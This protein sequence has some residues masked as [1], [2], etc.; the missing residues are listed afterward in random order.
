MTVD[1]F[2]LASLTGLVASPYSSPANVSTTFQGTQ[3]AEFNRTNFYLVHCNIVPDGLLYNNEYSSILSDVPI[4]VQPLRQILYNPQNPCQLSCNI[5]GSIITS[6]R[7]WITDDS[8]R[9]IST[10]EIWSVRMS[11]SYLIPQVI[12]DSNGKPIY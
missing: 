1:I 12:V 6:V 2:S 10:N 5:A 9:A 8:N 3:D 4:D 11:L 7:V